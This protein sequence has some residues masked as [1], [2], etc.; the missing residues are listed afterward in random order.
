MKRYFYYATQLMIIVIF[1]N[2][3]IEFFSE[4]SINALLEKPLRFFG[5]TILI[6]LIGGYILLNV[7]KKM[8]SN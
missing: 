8:D 2:F 7:N 1:S 5:A 3:V 6:G 4:G